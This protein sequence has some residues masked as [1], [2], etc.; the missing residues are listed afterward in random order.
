MTKAA[1]LIVAIGL[2]LVPAAWAQTPVPGSGA[3]Q[4]PPATGSMTSQ[5]QVAR[6]LQDAGL[7]NI[8]DVQMQSDGTWR[9]QVTSAEGVDVQAAVDALGNISLHSGVASPRQ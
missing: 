4:V 5:E 3:T 2:G 9:A 1:A 7:R 6:Q 8:R